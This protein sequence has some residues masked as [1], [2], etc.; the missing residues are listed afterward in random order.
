[1]D[2]SLPCLI[3]FDCIF[4]GEYAWLLEQPMQHQLAAESFFVSISAAWKWL[5][6]IGGSSFH[7]PFHTPFLSVSGRKYGSFTL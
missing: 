2:F 1:M 7:P 6:K 5:Q 4:T 3:E